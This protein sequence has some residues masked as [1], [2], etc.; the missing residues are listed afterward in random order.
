M[1]KIIFFILLLNFAF[2]QDE[3]PYPPLK[4]I[5]VPTGGTLPKGTFTFETLLM[6]NG[7]VLPSVSLGITDNLTFGVS[8]G[9][10]EFIGIGDLKKKQIIS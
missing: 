1:R 6:N 5:S 4:L 10:Q 2:V 8:F 9:I 7:G 3:Q